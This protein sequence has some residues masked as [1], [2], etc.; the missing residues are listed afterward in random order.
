VTFAEEVGKGEA[1]EHLLAIGETIISD[2]ELTWRFY[3]RGRI[4]RSG[5]GRRGWVWALCAGCIQFPFSFAF[6]SGTPLSGL[7]FKDNRLLCDILRFGE[8]NGLL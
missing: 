8:L 2:D 3:E 1:S 7:I 6:H 5:A 4:Q